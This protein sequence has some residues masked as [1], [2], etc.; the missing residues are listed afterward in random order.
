VGEGLAPA[1]V[2]T[3]EWVSSFFLASFF[4]VKKA[5]TGSTS[6]DSVSFTSAEGD[7][8]GYSAPVASLP[9]NRPFE[10]EG[11]SALVTIRKAVLR[12]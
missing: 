10:K 5:S 9:L 1:I 4:S 11:R 6:C 2:H 7:G 3:Y 8:Y 12:R